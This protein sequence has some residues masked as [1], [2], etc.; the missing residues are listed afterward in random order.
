MPVPVIAALKGYV[1]GGSFEKALHCH[2]R[3]AGDDV[4]MGLPEVGHGLVP[5]TGGVS[6]LCALAG[7]GLT[8]DMVLTGRLL[9]ASEALSGGVVSRVVPV[10]QLDGAAAE[11]AAQIAK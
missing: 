4:R 8:K 5:D 9:T 6:R 10:G 11:R 2:I 3:I 7:P 1:L